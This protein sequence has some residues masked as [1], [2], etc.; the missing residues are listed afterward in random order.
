MSFRISRLAKSKL[1]FKFFGKGFCLPRIISFSLLSSIPLL[2][3]AG[4][5]SEKTG[6]MIDAPSS[7]SHNEQLKAQWDYLGIEGPEHWGIL[8]EEYLTCETG[9]LQSP[10][11]ITMSHPGDHQ[12][13]IVFYYQTSQIYGLNNGHTIQVAHAAGC[14]VDLNDRK[15]KLRQFHFHAPSEHHIK[16]EAFPMEMHLV[17][18][19]IKGRVLVVAVMMKTDAKQPVLSK[20]WKWLP[21]QIGKEKSI[22]LEVRLMDIL[23]TSKDHYAYSGSLTTPPCTEG[24]QWIVLKEPMHVTQQDVDQFVQIIGP[25]ARPVQPLRDRQVKDH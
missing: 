21:D 24:V 3:F 7:T 23:P 2:A 6:K 5:F 14:R 17:H 11:N 10:I 25:N 8:N 1:T 9:N 16:G 18:Q 22:P 12:Q 19:D 20:L 15:Y 4:D 13:K